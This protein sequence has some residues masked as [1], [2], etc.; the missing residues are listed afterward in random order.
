MDRRQSHAVSSILVIVTRSMSG[1]FPFHG[2]NRDLGIPIE[3]KAALR[4]QDREYLADGGAGGEF[5]FLSMRSSFHIFRLVRCST[6]I[7]IK[8][9]RRSPN[10][11]LIMKT[12]VIWENNQE[13]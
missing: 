6:V 13:K 11:D 1:G 2:L 4:R 12:I 9:V 10:H 5:D 8:R 7:R 3:W